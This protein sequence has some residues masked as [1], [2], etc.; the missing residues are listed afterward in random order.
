MTSAIVAFPLCRQHKLVSGIAHVLR[1]K[2]GESAT[3]FWR[4]TAKA[5]LLQLTENGVGHE[6]AEEEVR[7][8]LYAVLAEIEADTVIAS[9]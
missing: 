7:G 3:L 1:S 8:L 4:E 5:L 2:Q 9:G 6:A